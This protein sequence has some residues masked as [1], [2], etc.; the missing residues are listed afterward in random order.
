MRPL[1]AAEFS[2]MCTV[3]A[4]QAL[5]SIGGGREER[6]RRVTMKVQE[7]DVTFALQ[8]V[9]FFRN[10]LHDNESSKLNASIK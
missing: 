2:G 1:T 5:L 10:I 4:D 7:D 9:R 8:G 6:L 3:L